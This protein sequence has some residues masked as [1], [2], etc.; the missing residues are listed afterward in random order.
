MPAT[1]VLE[2]PC[3]ALQ[4]VQRPRKECKTV[5]RRVGNV[6]AFKS[7]W[8]TMRQLTQTM[9]PSSADTLVELQETRES[10]GHL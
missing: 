3:K 4:K 7:A 9:A 8:E 10:R 2:S 6:D 1:A 5:E